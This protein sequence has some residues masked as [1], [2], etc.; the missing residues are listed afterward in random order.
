MFQGENKIFLHF[1]YHG[2]VANDLFDW[3]TSN[4]YFEVIHI[5]DRI[6]DLEQLGMWLLGKALDLTSVT[7][8]QG[9][10]F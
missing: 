10:F 4:L 6:K 9:K 2:G 1:P 3:Q 8:S 5:P 7:R